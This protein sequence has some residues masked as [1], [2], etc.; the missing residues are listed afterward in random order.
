MKFVEIETAK[1]FRTIFSSS[2][3]AWFWLLLRLYVGYQW[4]NAGWAKL[5]NPMWI[6]EN[7]G[8][9]VTGFLQGALSKATGAHP[10]V[11][12]WYVLFIQNIALPH[13]Q[14]FS[15]FV[16]YGELLVGIALIL[17]LFVGIAAT[18][19]GFMNFN[20]LF[21][22]TVSINPELL[23]LEFFLILAWRS[24]GWYG[25]D[26]WLLAMLGTPW[27]KGSWFSWKK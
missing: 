15:Y 26:R 1:F 21:A 24:A 4:F 9:A 5:F 18:F 3:F 27:K 19:A 2:K 8:A 25:L 7:A 11:S 17:G 10:D 6:G 12:S 16:T 20:Y 23:L 13:A 14:L 22:G